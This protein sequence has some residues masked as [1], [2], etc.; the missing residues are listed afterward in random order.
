MTD[1]S[2]YPPGTW[3]GDPRAPW[4]SPDNPECMNS[5]CCASLELDW[6]FCPYCGRHIDWSEYEVEE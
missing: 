3:Y 2:N 1:N 5:K 6:E 4:N